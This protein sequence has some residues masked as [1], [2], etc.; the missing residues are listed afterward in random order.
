M[1]AKYKRVIVTRYG[2]SE[3]LKVIEEDLPEPG[4]GEVRIR[5]LAA[6]ASFADVLLR[7]GIHP[8]ARRPPFTPGWDIVGRVDK[9]GPGILTPEIGQIVA[10]LPVVGGY[11]EYIC[12]PQTELIPVPESADPAEAVSLVLNYGTAYQMMYRSAH[13]KPYQRVLIHSAGGGVGTAL[14]QLGALVSLE[15]YGTASK[16]KHKMVSSLGGI[17]IDYK[18]VD[19]VDEIRRLTGDGVD[20]VFDAI[21]GRHLWRSYRTLRDGGTVVAF[22]HATSLINGTLTGGRRSRLRGLPTI[23]GYILASRLIPNRKKIVLYSIQ[24]LKR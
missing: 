18:Q 17:P 19:F 6:G 2:P 9:H 22:G 4:P 13:V 12:L 16:G 20:V 1:S 11:V 8:E 7:E 3:V 5:I 10:A 14:L 24:T 15:I 21:G 23:A